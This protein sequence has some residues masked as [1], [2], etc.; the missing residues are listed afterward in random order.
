MVKKIK[1][2]YHES[3]FGISVD[4]C[5]CGMKDKYY[6]YYKDPVFRE[7]Y[8]VIEIDES[9]FIETYDTL[10]NDSK[11]IEGGGGLDGNTLEIEYGDSD[12]Y[13]KLDIWSINFET[14]ERGLQGIY[15]VIIKIFELCK[16]KRSDIQIIQTSFAALNYSEISPL[17]NISISISSKRFVSLKRECICIHFK[18]SL[19]NDKE[20][21]IDVDIFNEIFDT[22]SNQDYKKIAGNQQIKSENNNLEIYFIKD[23]V[24]SRLKIGDIDYK[25]EERGLQGIYGVILQI[26]SICDIKDTSI[27][28]NYKNNN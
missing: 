1:I 2:A 12:N 23:K 17:F 19:D 26:L 13:D 5:I 11:N 9:I 3:F 7:E 10:L 8:E 6:L 25:T 4:I 22:L 20:K 18:D 21:I 15:D 27:Q 24:N 28:K 16:I 14:E